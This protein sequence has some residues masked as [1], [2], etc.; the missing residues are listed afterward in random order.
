[1]TATG[2]KFTNANKALRAQAAMARGELVEALGKSSPDSDA[3]RGLLETFIEYSEAA[4]ILGGSGDEDEDADDGESEQP[5]PSP[6]FQR[7]EEPSQDLAEPNCDL[8]LT[9]EVVPAADVVPVPSIAAPDFDLEEDQTIDPDADLTQIEPEQVEPDQTALD[10]VSEPAGAPDAGADRDP[11]LDDSTELIDIEHSTLVGEPEP[12]LVRLE[13][14]GPGKDESQ[15]VDW[16]DATRPAVIGR[17]GCQDVDIGLNDP[18]V[19]KHHCRL[20]LDASGHWVLEDLGSRN[21]TLED[22][23]PI[24]CSSP[25]KPGAIYLIGET[26]VNFLPGSVGD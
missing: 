18:S 24:N 11:D 22:G 26:V 21:G 13:I 23:K 25:V 7:M 12:V 17:V 5:Q 16:S 10:T 1:M 19:S 20:F 6:D 9:E 14:T 8:V 15:T 3:L 2:K 4:E